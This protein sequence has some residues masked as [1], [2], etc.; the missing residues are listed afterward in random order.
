M[1]C[2]SGATPVRV[3][4]VEVPKQDMVSRGIRHVSSYI[5]NNLVGLKWKGLIR[6]WF[7]EEVGERF[8]VLY[9]L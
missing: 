4:Q 5:G 2:N 1:G 6:E 9:T 3:M 8:R 7:S